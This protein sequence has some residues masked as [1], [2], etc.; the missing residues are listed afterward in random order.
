M[1]L[2]TN[3]IKVI[4]MIPTELQTTEASESAKRAEAEVQQAD[5]ADAKA[6]LEAL[7]KE[8]KAKEGETNEVTA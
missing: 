6:K 5:P 1:K 3:A 7:L 8:A 2:N 4:H